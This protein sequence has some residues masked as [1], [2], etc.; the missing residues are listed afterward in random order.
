MLITHF[1]Y[2]KC[3]TVSPLLPKLTVF[4]MGTLCGDQQYIY[5]QYIPAYNEKVFI[6]YVSRLPRFSYCV[7]APTQI[8]VENFGMIMYDSIYIYIYI[9][10]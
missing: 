2:V 1:H 3:V 8:D 9:S 4:N 7:W 6:D 5:L 10:Y